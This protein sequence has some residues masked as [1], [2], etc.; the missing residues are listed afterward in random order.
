MKIKVS[1]GSDLVQ[2]IPDIV[3]LL[4]NPPG[5]RRDVRCGG[6]T[7]DPG[8]QQGFISDF[9]RAFAGEL[10]IRSYPPRK[11]SFY[12][13]TAKNRV[14]GCKI[15]DVGAGRRPVFPVEDRPLGCEYVGLDISGS[16][17]AAAPAGSYDRC[18]EGDVCQPIPELCNE[19]DLV[20]SWQL[21]EHVKPL[22]D[23]LDNI[24]SYLKPGGQFV[25]KLSGSFS[26]F[27][28]IN[29]LL[30]FWATRLMLRFT[31][32]D[33]ATVFPAY[34]HH[35]WATEIER[36]MRKWTSSDVI[37]LYHGSRYLVKIR[38]LL[39]LYSLYEN[40][41][42]TSARVNLATHYIIDARR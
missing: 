24:Y 3:A 29:R 1:F 11:Q 6:E 7:A 5:G 15:L 22:D 31:G 21:L 28:M 33:P 13:L 17:L 16:E 26:Y 25:A 27:A 36:I 14:Q 42:M 19:F 38:P 18:V 30:P 8:A 4:M 34:Y 2:K 41:A 10:P 32:R 23:A 12:A 20:I 37:P 9:K 40:W 39:A 35:C